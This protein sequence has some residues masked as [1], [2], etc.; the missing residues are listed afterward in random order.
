M[1]F[2]K[3]LAQMQANPRRIAALVADVDAQ[4]ASWK[5]TPDTWSI[6]E[7]LGHLREEERMDFR[8]RLDLILNHPGA[9]WPPIDPAGWVTA[10][11]YNQGDLGETL[12]DYLNERQKSLG[13]LRGLVDPDWDKSETAPWG[14]ISAGDM[15]ASWAGHD[16][17]HMRQLVELLRAYTVQQSGPYSPDYAGDW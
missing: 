7:V 6:L 5:P 4:Q 3:I 1:N 11:A 9:A 12:D 16:L 14:S 13:W 8:V 17:L 2:E 10:H 15:L